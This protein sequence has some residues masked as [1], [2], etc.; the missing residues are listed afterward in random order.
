MTTSQAL[1]QGAL[2]AARIIS[3]PDPRDSRKY[4]QKVQPRNPLEA[5][6]KNTGTQLYK[7]MQAE[8]NRPR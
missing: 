8:Q 7:A 1:T 5:A 3:N 4:R 2:K 6:W